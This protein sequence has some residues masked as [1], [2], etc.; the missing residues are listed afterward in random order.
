MRARPGAGRRSG[1][2]TGIRGQR[3][4]LTPASGR[5]EGAVNVVELKMF[6]GTGTIVLLFF[7]EYRTAGIALKK[8]VAADFVLALHFLFAL[9]AVGGGFLALLDWRVIFLH[10]PAVVW[11]SVVNLAHWTCPLTPLERNLRREAGQQ[12]FEGTWTQNYIEPLVRPLGMP[13]RMELIAGVSIVLWNVIV[14]GTVF[15]NGVAA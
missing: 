14:Y 5:A 1:R 10:F 15:R 9:F 7:R 13:R 6:G 2:G 4:L 3:F 12:A 8:V 11:S